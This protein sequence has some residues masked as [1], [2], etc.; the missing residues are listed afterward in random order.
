MFV[1][2]RPTLT[3]ATQEQ[4]ASQIP[5]GEDASVGGSS[6]PRPAFLSG[7]SD[8]SY[9]LLVDQLMNP[10][11]YRL[12]QR[13]GS[14]REWGFRYGYTIP[15]HAG[16]SAPSATQERWI[17]AFYEQTAMRRLLREVEGQ[18]RHQSIH[19]PTTRPLQNA[20]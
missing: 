3:M 5:E 12:G 14:E 19:R 16:D 2:E 17:R 1:R 15:D 7:R 6:A 4:N 11:W 13:A 8:A 9:W 20:D 10:G 18:M